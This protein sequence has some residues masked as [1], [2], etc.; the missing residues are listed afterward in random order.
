[1]FKWIAGALGPW[2][3]VFYGGIITLALLAIRWRD[4]RLI[5]QGRTEGIQYEHDRLINEKREEWAA[6]EKAFQT[7]AEELLKRRAE[8]ES[9]MRDFIEGRKQERAALRT[10]LTA[11]SNKLE[12]VRQAA[13]TAPA[14]ELDPLIK[15]AL[16]ELAEPV[17][18]VVKPSPGGPILPPPGPPPK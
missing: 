10:G 4:N 5:N 8:V 2:Q 17:Q 18:G 1:M 3:W 12:D 15:K 16:A 11:I 14:S 9:A 13:F 7:A 6:K